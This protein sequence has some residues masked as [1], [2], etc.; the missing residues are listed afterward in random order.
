MRAEAPVDA[1][2]LLLGVAF[3]SHTGNDRHAAAVHDGLA[4]VGEKPVYD[5]VVDVRPRDLLR[6]Q[7]SRTSEERVDRIEL[8]VGQVQAQRFLTAQR[9]SGP[10]AGMMDTFLMDRSHRCTDVTRV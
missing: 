3:R 1:L 2:K 8:G 6:L 10:G 9:A 4:H 7:V 5:G